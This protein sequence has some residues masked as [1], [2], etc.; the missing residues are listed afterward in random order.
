[1]LPQLPREGGI[2]NVYVKIVDANDAVVAFTDHASSKLDLS[3]I[4]TIGLPPVSA[5][6]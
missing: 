3:R 4:E 5:A 6:E 1:V 2:Q